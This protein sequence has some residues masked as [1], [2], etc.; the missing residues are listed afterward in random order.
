MFEIKRKTAKGFCWQMLDN[1]IFQG[2]LIIAIS[3]PWVSLRLPE[4]PAGRLHPRLFK[5]SIF[6]ALYP[7]RIKGISH[8]SRTP[9]WLLRIPN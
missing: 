9:E 1:K 2:W 5:L 3:L 8:L 4:C 7:A 6:S